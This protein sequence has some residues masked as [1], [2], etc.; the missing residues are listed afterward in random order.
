MAKGFTRNT[1]TKK[2][3][4]VL[5]REKS[6]KVSQ[7]KTGAMTLLCPFCDIPHPIQANIK[8]PCGTL[9]RVMA[10]QTIYKSKYLPE[11]V[12]CTKCGKSGGEMTKF[13]D[14][15]IHVLDC[16]P[17][18]KVLSERP[19]FSRSA[20]WAFKLK[21]G[22][23]KQW[24]IRKIGIPQKVDEITPTGERTGKVLGYVFYRSVENE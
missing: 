10:V 3:S 11:E 23:L 14:G 24:I 18:V 1:V 6:P 7:D 15:F 21:D 2:E 20:K 22:K 8:S 19:P 16:T 12:I 5:E 17:G 4:K 13:N 9:L